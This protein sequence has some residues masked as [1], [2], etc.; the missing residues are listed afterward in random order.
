MGMIIILVKKGMQ[1]FNARSL[2]KKQIDP[3]QCA[4]NK[5][6]KN[7]PLPHFQNSLSRF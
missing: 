6:L 4:G 5:S 7:Q 2:Y 1:S 3:K